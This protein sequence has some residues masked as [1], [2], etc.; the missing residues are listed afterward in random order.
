M[1]VLRAEIVI[2]EGLEVVAIGS[3]WGDGL[4]AGAMIVT[5]EDESLAALTYRAALLDTA[6]V[7]AH[8]RPVFRCARPVCHG[9]CRIACP[10]VQRIVKFQYIGSSCSR[11]MESDAPIPPE[12]TP[13]YELNRTRFLEYLYLL[14]GRDNPEHSDHAL[15]SGLVQEYRIVIG[16]QV[17]EHIVRNWE[18]VKDE[19]HAHLAK[20]REPEEE[21]CSLIS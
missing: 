18:L 7:V 19:F 10:G 6:R 9:A 8:G 5:L 12:S 3:E 2:I 20:A 14:D 1:S 4:D 11:S 15:Y 21:A 16:Q 13:E 17:I